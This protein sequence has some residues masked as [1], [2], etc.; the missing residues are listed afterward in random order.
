M[1]EAPLWLQR[2]QYFHQLCI[3]CPP[4]FGRGCWRGFVFPGTHPQTAPMV[5]LVSGDGLG[6]PLPVLRDVPRQEEYRGTSLIRNNP[7]LGPY[8]RIVPRALWMS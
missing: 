6:S 5:L 1:S 4:G 3:L 7:P 8:G 2:L